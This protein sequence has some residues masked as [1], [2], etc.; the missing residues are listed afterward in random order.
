MTNEQLKFKKAALSA[1]ALAFVLT[2]CADKQSEAQTPQPEVANARGY[3]VSFPQCDGEL[4]NDQAFGIVGLNGTLANNF[5]DCFE[6]QIAWAKTS[7]G[8]S[9]QPAVAI[10]VHIGNPGSKAASHWPQEG[11]NRYGICNGGDTLACDYEYGAN[12]ARADIQEAAGYGAATLMT[13]LD[14]EPNYSWQKDTTRNVAAMEGMVNAFENAGAPVGIY[15][16][17]DI[18]Q[19][20]AGA[21]PD[22]SE[23]S[24]LPNWVLGAGSLEEAKANCRTAG[25]TGEVVLAQIADN[26]QIDRDIT[27]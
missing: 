26:V 5:N 7:S 2:A 24:G 21:V 6:E 18:W 25:F 11:S 22:S 1:T 13:W 19:Q 8:E 15:S 14:V 4:P 23:L 3:D 17:A 10:Y 20:L 27:C 9:S 12:L 16:N